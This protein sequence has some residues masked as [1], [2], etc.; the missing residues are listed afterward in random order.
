VLERVVHPHGSDATGTG[1][2][3]S[4][5]KTLSHAL[6]AAPDGA[7]IALRQGVY[8]RLE[9]TGFDRGTALTVA[10][11]G[12]E[13]VTVGG[14]ALVACAGLEFERFRVVGLTGH[15]LDGPCHDLWFRSLDCV[16]E[17]GVQW[18]LGRTAGGAERIRWHGCRLRDAVASDLVADQTLENGPTAIALRNAKTAA[19]DVE[20]VGCDFVDLEGFDAVHCAAGST[21]AA[22]RATAITVAHNRLRRVRAGRTRAHADGVQ[23][24]GYSRAIT[25]A[26]N[27]IEQGRGFIVQPS[28]TSRRGDHRDLVIAANRFPMVTDFCATV[29][30]AP[31]VRIERNWCPTSHGRVSADPM[32]WNSGI[33][34]NRAWPD[35]VDAPTDDV[36]LDDN[37]LDLLVV[38]DPQIGFVSPRR[39]QIRR[40]SG[41]AG[42]GSYSEP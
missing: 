10:G 36:V 24:T 19:R 38:T 8:P 31:G 34:I 12:R 3:L 23:L 16:G 15:E 17:F 39:N 21:H 11:Y 29:Y 25:I 41:H 4:P 7:R 9:L 2:L 33:R 6:E 32:D 13:D 26:H 14:F 18:S 28:A 40:I 35:A 1:S 37:D 5:W 42:A 27:A 30:N 20:V 22:N